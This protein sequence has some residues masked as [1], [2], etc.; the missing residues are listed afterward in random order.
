MVAPS[1]PMML[2]SVMLLFLPIPGFNSSPIPLGIPAPILLGKLTSLIKISPAMK[3]SFAKTLLAFPSGG[4]MFEYKKM[5]MTKRGGMLLAA[6]VASA[7]ATAGVLAVTSN[8]ESNDEKGRGVASLEVEK[9][10][11]SLIAANEDTNAASLQQT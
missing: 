8:N 11:R 4:S 5:D 6:G 10:S 9:T 3:E 2:V 1:F 7:T